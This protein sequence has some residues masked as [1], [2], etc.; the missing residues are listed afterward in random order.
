VATARQQTGMFGYRRSAELATSYF[1]PRSR[2]AD[3]V[4][5][6]HVGCAMWTHKAWPGQ[7]LPPSLPA[8]ERLRAYA[9][10]CDAVEGNTTF[11]C[12]M[13]TSVHLRA[14]S[15][16][17]MRKTQAGRA[18]PVRVRPQLEREA[19]R[20]EPGQV[21]MVPAFA[22]GPLSVQPVRPDIGRPAAGED[23][24]AERSLRPGRPGELPVMGG[25]R[26]DRAGRA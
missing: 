5:R 19:A 17:F 23:V 11:P 22:W 2:G 7:F 8:T 25:E 4:A 16:Y 3:E 24:E 18:H 14:V 10:W 20:Y 9:R 15:P 13:G 21:R 1:H 6:L 12:T 26:A